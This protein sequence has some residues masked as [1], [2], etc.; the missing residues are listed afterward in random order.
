MSKNLDYSY[1]L[2][3]EISDSYVRVYIVPYFKKYGSFEK[4][5]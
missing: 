4:F 3:E 2:I 1:D 5:T